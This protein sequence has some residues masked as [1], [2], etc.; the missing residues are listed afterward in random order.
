MTLEGI[1]GNDRSQDTDPAGGSPE[2]KVNHFTSQTAEPSAEFAAPLMGTDLEPANG[3]SQPA[4]DLIDTTN[5][6]GLI[7][8]SATEFAAAQLKRDQESFAAANLSVNTGLGDT[9]VQVFAEDA[10]N[11]SFEG[12]LVEFGTNL[13]AVGWTTDTTGDGKSGINLTHARSIP[14]EI[15]YRHHMR[16]MRN[17]N[18][19]IPKLRSSQPL[20]KYL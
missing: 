20:F 14:G 16:P 4:R 12:I 8:D 13:K 17:P 18:R 15:A 7:A 6:Q 10:A 1:Q 2:F 3:V 9:E 5:H 19:S 11:T